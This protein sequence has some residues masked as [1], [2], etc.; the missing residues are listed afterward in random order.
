LPRE[1][2]LSDQERLDKLHLEVSKWEAAL[3]EVQEKYNYETRILKE[4]TVS[5]LEKPP[6]P[7][8]KP[9]R[10]M[11]RILKCKY[12]SVCWEVKKSPTETVKPT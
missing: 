7:A 5:D 9:C 4:I 3:K 2:P 6:Q 11:C 10:M 8:L 1:K 12:D